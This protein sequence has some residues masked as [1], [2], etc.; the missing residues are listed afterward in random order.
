MSETE[1][2]PGYLHSTGPERAAGLQPPS[3][4]FVGCTNPPRPE[5]CH[6]DHWVPL[7]WPLQALTGI[8][9]GHAL[10]QNYPFFIQS[11][12][13]SSLDAF[14]HSEIFA[15]RR[16]WLSWPAGH[17]LWSAGSHTGSYCSSIGEAKMDWHRCELLVVSCIPI[18]YSNSSAMSSTIFFTC[19][20]SVVPDALIKVF[21]LF[22]LLCHPVNCNTAQCKV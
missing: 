10:C 2:Q 16:L 17:L 14:L 13:Q 9:D 5:S 22:L 18:T 4:A 11:L 15:G 3:T 12:F 7:Q 8:C 6:P 1:L 20:P 19:F 21:N